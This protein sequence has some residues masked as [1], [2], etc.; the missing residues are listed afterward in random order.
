MEIYG[1]S[2][3]HI[4]QTWREDSPVTDDD[5]LFAFSLYGYTRLRVYYNDKLMKLNFTKHNC[6]SVTKWAICNRKVKF[7]AIICF[8]VL[9]RHV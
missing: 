8:Y 3:N 2:T 6:A 5:L 9:I 4:A 1:D 7:N